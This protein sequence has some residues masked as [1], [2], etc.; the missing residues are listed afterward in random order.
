ML[1]LVGTLPF[2]CV[3]L[4][5]NGVMAVLCEAGYEKVAFVRVFCSCEGGQSKDRAKGVARRVTCCTSV[6]RGLLCM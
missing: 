5:G 2:C 1:S 6:F 3:Q 4:R